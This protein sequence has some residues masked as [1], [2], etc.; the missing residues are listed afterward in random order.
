MKP[1]TLDC[2]PGVIWE[3]IT[4][5]E[6]AQDVIAKLYTSN[7]A[8]ATITSCHDGKHSLNSGHHQ[9]D[10]KALSSAIDLR[11]MNLFRR[12]PI[13]NGAEWFNLVLGFAK[14]LAEAL[15]DWLSETNRHGRFD[16]VLESDHL[17]VEYSDVYHPNII[18]WT[19]VK[20]VYVSK[21]AQKYLS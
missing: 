8:K 21:D 11:I 15:N 12:V 1:C 3:A 2:K 7:G 4:E 5:I 9:N 6:D 10:H 18:G 16:V 14:N 13:H 20:M 19:E 17:H